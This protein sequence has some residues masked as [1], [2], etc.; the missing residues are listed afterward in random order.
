MLDQINA[1][2]NEPADYA[3]GLALLKQTGYRGFLLTVLAM[4]EDAYTRSRL[5][6]E[7]RNYL[8]AP[9]NVSSAAVIVAPNAPGQPV[10]SLAQVTQKGE[11]SFAAGQ[12]TVLTLDDLRTMTTDGAVNELKQRSYALMDERA[13]LK[14]LI[15]ATMDDPTTQDDRRGRAFRIKAITRELDEVFSHLDF[16]AQHGYL[17]LTED[18]ATVVDETAALMNARS[19]VSRYRAKLKRPNLTPEQRQSAEALLRQYEAEKNRLQLK[20]NR[21]S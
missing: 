2:L 5:E 4:G 19:Y 6:A 12:G 9:T 13:E 7:L 21:N 1:W 3:T 14:A 15:R 20:L 18:P 8:T 16:H 10:I 17:P 11:E